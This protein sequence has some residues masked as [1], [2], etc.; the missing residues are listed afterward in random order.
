MVCI[1]FNDKVSEYFECNIGVRQGDSLSPTLFNVFIND[2]ANELET[3]NDVS[4]ILDTVNISFLF[5]AD[6][7][8]LLSESDDG[9]Q[10][11]INVVDKYCQ[12]WALQ[13]NKSKSKVM[14]FNKNSTANVEFTVGGE[15]L[16]KVKQYKYLGILI[17][18]S[19]SF[20]QGITQLSKKALK[21][22]FALK[23]CLSTCSYVPIEVAVHCFDSIIKPILMY[24]VEIWGQDILH[25]AKEYFDNFV[26]SKSDIE[27]IH[28][29]FCKSLLCV[30]STTSNLA[31]LSELGRMSM[32]ISTIQAILRYHC[33]L[34]SMQNS[35]FVTE[36]YNVGKDKRFHLHDIATHLCDTIGVDLDSYNF[37]DFKIRKKYQK[38]VRAQ[39]EYYYKEEWFITLSSPVGKTGMGN[40]LRTYKSFNRK[41]TC[42]KYFSDISNIS[43]RINL[44]K[45]RVIAH[46]LRIERGRYE[47]VNNRMVP[48]RDYIC[49][50][51]STNEIEDEFHFVMLCPLLLRICL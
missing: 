48:E 50:Y 21:C 17:S 16:E 42:E 32:I 24:G 14:I 39:L 11:L 13:I 9:L 20:S 34:E 4:A 41:L 37:A 36:V 29:K 12:R 15:T 47:R 25:N 33:R 27:S 23:K 30:P 46:Q 26:H 8:V 7:L 5:Y 51:C 1:R 10:T 45:L 31:V 44:T 35:R 2:L 49:K 3:Y 19:G 6:D 18:K 43:Y 28:I 38:D 22:C 40:K